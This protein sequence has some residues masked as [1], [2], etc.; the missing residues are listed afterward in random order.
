MDLATFR[1]R[2]TVRRIALVLAAAALGYRIATVIAALQAGD[3]S[4]LLAFPFGAILPA[5]LLVVLVAL[6]P[7]RT[8]EGLLMRAGAMIQLWLIILLPTVALYLALGFPVVFL[9]V[10]LFETR[11]PSQIR[12]PLTRLVVA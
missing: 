11:L 1:F 4:L 6:P 9:V 12:D 3:P 2:S 7:T 5:V 10:E 8:R